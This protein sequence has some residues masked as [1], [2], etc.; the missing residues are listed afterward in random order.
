MFFCE[1]S[2]WGL[3]LLHG[4]TCGNTRQAACVPYAQNVT[5]RQGKGNFPWHCGSNREK[6]EI[7]WKSLG[8]GNSWVHSGAVHCSFYR[9]L[10]SRM[11]FPRFLAVPWTRQL[12][13]ASWISFFFFINKCC[14][15]SC[16]ISSIFFLPLTDWGSRDLFS[17]FTVSFSQAQY[18][19]FKDFVGFLPINL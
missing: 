4:K 18:I 15:R 3:V 12:T 5:V 9:V 11:Y 7:T 10:V 14:A 8:N 6:L 13:L 19:S 16:D 1:A 17:W 2:L